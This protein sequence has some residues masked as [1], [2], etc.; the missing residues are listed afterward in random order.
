M[1]F[2][3][4]QDTRYL[5]F[6]KRS[7]GVVSVLDEESIDRPTVAHQVRRNK[8]ASSTASERDPQNTSIF[9]PISRLDDDSAPSD[10]PAHTGSPA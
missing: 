10:G 1:A 6:V 8:Q 7:K 5:F 9:G 2:A 4:F 3:S